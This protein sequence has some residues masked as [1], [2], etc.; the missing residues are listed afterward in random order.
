MK[1]FMLIISDVKEGE[2]VE[3]IV[4]ILVI[5]FMCCLPNANLSPTTLIMSK[6]S[7]QDKDQPVAKSSWYKSIL[8]QAKYIGARAYRATLAVP[9]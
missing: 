6:L 3:N 7:T 4:N 8:L 1:L 2:G 5:S 9:S